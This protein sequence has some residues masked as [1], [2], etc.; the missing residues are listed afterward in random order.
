MLCNK[1]IS[2]ASIFNAFSSSP[3]KS[4]DVSALSQM[5]RNL[6]IRADWAR[7][8]LVHAC[9]AGVSNLDVVSNS[10]SFDPSCLIAFSKRHTP[11]RLSPASIRQMI[12]VPIVKT[13]EYHGESTW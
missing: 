6:T 12:E 7:G 9:G 10:L 3:I 13:K 4:H 11:P 8:C 1:P 5:G 2:A